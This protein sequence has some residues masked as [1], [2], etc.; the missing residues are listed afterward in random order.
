MFDSVDDW[1]IIAVVVGIL[2]YGSSKIPQL[3]NALGRSMGEF[4]RGKAQVEREMAAENAARANAAASPTPASPT[5]ST[6]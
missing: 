5:D 6:H 3:A 2:F 4:K 1:L